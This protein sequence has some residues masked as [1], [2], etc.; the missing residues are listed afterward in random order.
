MS[1]QNCSH[2]SAI[3]NSAPLPFHLP[4]GD[5]FLF[6]PEELWRKCQIRFSQ[7]PL[8]QRPHLPERAG[9]WEPEAREAWAQAVSLVV[10]SQRVQPQRVQA[11]RVRAQR[12]R[13]QRARAQRVQAQRARAQRVRAQRV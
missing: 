5:W 13:A 11:Q 9:S 7:R 4:W 1:C 6:L 12:A 10:R 3:Q 2:P 8:A